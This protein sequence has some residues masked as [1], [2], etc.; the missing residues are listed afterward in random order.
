MTART[1]A[2]VALIALAALGLFG[3]IAAAD[4]GGWVI[5]RFAADIQIQPDGRLRVEEAIDVDF[6]TQQKHGIFRSIPV[7]YEWPAKPRTVRVYQLQ[8][9][10]VRDDRDR[11]LHYETSRD[12]AAYVIK[13]GDPDRT[14]TG[15][16]RYRI[17]YLVTGALNSFADHDEL[18]WNVTGDQWSVPMLAA[19]AVVSAPAAPS[20]TACYV[21]ASGSRDPCRIART[22]ATATTF[23]A[24]SPLS[25]GEQLTVVDALRKGVVPEPQ[26]IL[27]DRPREFT[28]FF[29]LTP[30]WLAL[31]VFVAI[32]GAVLVWWRWWTA[33]RDAPDRVTIVAEY[34]PPDK[35]RPAQVGLLIDERADT[36]DVTATI[37]DLAVR[38][39]L[40]IAEVPKQG[41]FGSRDWL[42]TRKRPAD[43]ALL[44]YEQTILDGLFALGEGD[45]VKLS[46][47]KRHFYK[48][49]G[50]AEGQLYS[51]AVERGWFPADPNRVRATYAVAGIG[52]VV[53]AGLIAA[54]LGYLAG[55]GL[56]GVGFALPATL[57]V[58]VSP[59]MPRKTKDGAEL[60]RRAAGFRQYMEVAE[61]DRQR[62]AER[63]H[64]FADY[65]PYAIVFKCVEQWA[66]AFAGID[67]TAATAGWYTGSNLGAF[68]AASFSS[69]I[70]GFSEHISTAIASTPGGSGSS[71]FGGG[72]GGG[73]GGGGG[74]SW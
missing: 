25:P 74:G 68:N 50:E 19:S 12:G 72:A 21:G 59:L 26:P 34:E 46:A 24:P 9:V 63:E 51:D 28:E 53:L 54:G 6:G 18:F 5:Q 7:Q 35:M 44:P 62:F 56:V 41:L 11:P 70:S 31:A 48:T 17:T 13:I 14:I 38:G 8:I 1:A 36:L 73:G 69:D 67:L 2:L 65:L 29:D 45:E 47:L 66:K 61:K 3:G 71:G 52:F 49:L 33:G 43:D 15:A 40:T 27:Q 57:L 20:Q 32:A 10:S 64:I 4:D 42:L 55:G 39:Y 37:I 30:V 22:S 23:T 60:A 16:Q 58:A